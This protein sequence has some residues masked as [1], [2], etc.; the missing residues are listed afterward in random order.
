MCAVWSELRVPEV[1]PKFAELAPAETVTLGADNTNAGLS[2][3]RAMVAA[4][5]EFAMETLQVAV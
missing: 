3:D 4:P 2:L 1:M 5:P